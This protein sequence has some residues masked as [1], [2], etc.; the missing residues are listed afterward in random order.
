MWPV[1][2]CWAWFGVVWFAGLFLR[3]PRR[4]AW[5]GTAGRCLW[6]RPPWGL[7]LGLVVYSALGGVLFPRGAPGS[8]GW[9]GMA[10]PAWLVPL[11][12]VFA[13]LPV[14]VS[15]PVPGVVAL[16]PFLPWC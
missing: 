9:G 15:S 4:D 8:A 5:P 12:W 2:G 16:F 10:P 6:A 1:G 14:S 7:C 3:G 13:C 11:L